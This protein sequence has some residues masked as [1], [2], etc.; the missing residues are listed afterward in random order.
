MKNSA[1]QEPASPGECLFS[2]LTKRGMTQSELAVR[3]GV[4]AK[5]YFHG[6]Q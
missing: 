3:T 5:A 1:A 4:S 6:H 2:E